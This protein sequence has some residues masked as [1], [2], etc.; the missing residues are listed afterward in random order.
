M[1]S[2]QSEAALGR[3]TTAAPDE[4]KQTSQVRFRIGPTKGGQLFATH[5]VRAIRVTPISLY[6]SKFPLSLLILMPSITTVHWMCFQVN[7]AA[8]RNAPGT[9]AAF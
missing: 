3:S 5:Y 8:F 1:R 2:R 6:R 9:S 4:V 7:G